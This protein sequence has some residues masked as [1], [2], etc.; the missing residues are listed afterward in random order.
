MKQ[1]NTLG[2]SIDVQ[3]LWNAV[4]FVPFGAISSCVFI[5]LI[6]WFS[7]FYLANPE[8]IIMASGTNSSLSEEWV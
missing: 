7:R 5:F 6:F 1:V 3:N 8:K 2:A 4:T